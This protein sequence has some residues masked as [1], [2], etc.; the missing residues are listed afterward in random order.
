MIRGGPV[1]GVDCDFDRIADVVQPRDWHPRHRRRVRIP[2]RG[3]VG[4]L[5]PDQPPVRN[6]QIRIRVIEEERGHALHPFRDAAVD[7]Q[8]ALFGEVRREER[9]RRPELDRKHQPAEH[10]RE[11]Y[12]AGAA[13]RREDV[14]LA[15][16]V[17]EFLGLGLDEHVGVL[18]L[19]V[20]DRRLRHIEIDRRDEWKIPNE[21]HRE[22]LGG[23][24]VDGTEG[25]AI[26]VGERQVLVDPGAARQR[27]GVQLAGRQHDLTVLP[28]D[29][30]AVV[31][32]GGEIVV[33]TDLLKL[34]ERVE[35]RPVVPE[36]NV[37]DGGPVALEIGAGEVGL[38]GEWPFDHGVEAERCARGPEVVTDEW[39]FTHLFV[40]RDHE[41]LDDRGIGA[42]AD[43]AQHVDAGGR[44]D[45]P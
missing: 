26:S 41:P 37:V 23:D 14:V 19:A 28:V 20:I 16:R 27:L 18:Q 1:V 30:V 44:G 4:V 12:A 22:T 31:V 5:H 29:Q 24:L 9:V 40:R 2:V 8:A 10:V 17:I 21:E 7:H 25:Q 39:G 11:R 15:A 42:A 6:R 3:G 33:G 45:R 36:R 34:S 13:I 38:S 35:Q 43:G 32:D